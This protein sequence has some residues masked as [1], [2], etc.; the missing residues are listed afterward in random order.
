MSNLL[1]IFNMIGKKL[2]NERNV[3][4]EGYLIV[5]KCGHNGQLSKKNFRSI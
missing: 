2:I 4:N 3:G 5:T 1:K